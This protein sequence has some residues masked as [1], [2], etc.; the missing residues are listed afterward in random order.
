MHAASGVCVEQRVCYVLRFVPLF[1]H[2]QVVCLLL[3]YTGYK[4]HYQ[5]IQHVDPAAIS[6]PLRRQQRH[7]TWTATLHLCIQANDECLG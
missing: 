1:C 2:A 3:L 5:Q 6:A 7:R 4:H